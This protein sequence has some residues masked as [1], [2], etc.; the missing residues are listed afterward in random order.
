MPIPVTCECG[1]RF[2]TRDENAGRRARCPDC[3]REFQVPEPELFRI[4]DLEP[5]VLPVA[6][7]SE[8]AIASLFLGLC[9]CGMVFT[10]IPAV[11]LGLFALRE[12]NRS[13]GRIKGKWLAIA[14]IALGILST[15][16]MFMPHREALGGTG[17]LSA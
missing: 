1:Q 2:Q 3:G 4:D 17:V 9:V 13:H 14:G 11:I 8:K 12:I 5:R 16:L 15:I 10:G 7:T 6:T